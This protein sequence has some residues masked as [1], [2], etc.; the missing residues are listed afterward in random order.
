MHPILLESPK[1]TG[2]YQAAEAQGRMLS[3]LIQD[4]A[5]FV[6]RQEDP[7]FIQNMEIFLLL[8]RGILRMVKEM[9]GIGRNIN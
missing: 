2:G 5:Q 8:S 9:I 7:L 1:P 3:E 6:Q 4:N